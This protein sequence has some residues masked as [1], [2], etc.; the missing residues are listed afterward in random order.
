M[1][2]ADQETI[3]RLVDE[4]P[5][6]TQDQRDAIRAALLRSVIDTRRRTDKLCA[7]ALGGGPR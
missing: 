1:I 4:A 7:D 6:L 2:P 5:P 3:R